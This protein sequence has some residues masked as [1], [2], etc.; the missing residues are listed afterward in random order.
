M[1]FNLRKCHFTDQ[2]V[3]HLYTHSIVDPR[4]RL[5]TTSY[6]S[7]IS[8][9]DLDVATSA[10][11]QLHIFFLHLGQNSSLET[12]DFPFTLRPHAAKIK[13]N[14]SENDGN[15]G[16][17]ISEGEGQQQ[18]EGSELGEDEEEKFGIIDLIRQPVD[19][20]EDLS[21]PPINTS[22]R[23]YVTTLERGGDTRVRI[24]WQ[25]RDE[26]TNKILF[27]SLVCTSLV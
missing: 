11:L 8:N 27:S 10:L 4:A 17:E 25:M 16:T 23:G 3:A 15:D 22:I 19:F 21:L 18:D 6:Y 2:L 5:D 12:L 14:R 7:G 26:F 9:S 20:G 1:F 24:W 13:L